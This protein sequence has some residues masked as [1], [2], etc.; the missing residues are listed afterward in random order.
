[1]K[2][3]AVIPAYN[4]E[5]TIADIVARALKHVDEVLV[6]DDGSIDDTSRMASLAGAR[7]IRQENRGVFH[8]S[9]KGLRSADGDVL[10]TLDADGQ[11]L[12]EE[13]PEL[14]KP[15]LENRAD[16]VVGGRPSFPHL[17]EKVITTLTR[18][19]VPVDDACT[20]YRAV[21]RSILRKMDPHGACLCGVFVLEGVRAGARVSTVPVSI[22]ERIDERRMNTMHIKQVFWVMFALFRAANL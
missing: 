6:V 17:S 3:T 7:V 22:R 10:V 20:G 21:R 8:A 13:I 4:E 12:P 2:I 15:I 19:R 14:V 18:L 1:M 16:L 11:H 9:M 5:K